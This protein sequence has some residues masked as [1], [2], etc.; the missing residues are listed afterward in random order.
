MG[1]D[2]TAGDAGM[3]DM[4]NVGQERAPDSAAAPARP[5]FCLGHSHVITVLNAKA[6]RKHTAFADRL[7]IINLR[8]LNDRPV[9]EGMPPAELKP[10]IAAQISQGP[11]FSCI[12]GNAH[13]ALGMVRNPRPFDFVLASEPDLPIEEGAEVIPFAVM[14]AVM[15][16][17]MVERLKL[18]LLVKAAAG[19]PMRH[20]ESPPPLA[21]SQFIVDNMPAQMVRHRERGS[22]SPVL[23]YKLWRLQSAIIA[24][25]CA[26]NDI[27]FI[28]APR[29]AMT[30]D[31]LLRTD[32]A[33]DI[34]HGNVAY[35]MLVLDQME[36]SL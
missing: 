26:D 12:G 35:G 14:E 29:E 34:S 31:G 24:G 5:V 4:S 19:G 22:S 32:Y 18:M 11:V 7:V 3:Q 28:P 17:R 23:R 20:L 10:E 1:V 25:V 15:R 36:A 33:A 30:T 9:S 16:G 2:E 13:N 27:P 6:A 8:E 21:D